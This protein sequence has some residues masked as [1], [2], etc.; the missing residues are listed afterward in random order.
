MSQAHACCKLLLTNDTGIR[1]SKMGSTS[2]GAKWTV[3]PEVLTGIYAL[4]P[5][6]RGA[7]T[8]PALTVTGEI[9]PLV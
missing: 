7:G 9:E 5:S 3:P 2:S 1:N 4:A 6:L 8:R